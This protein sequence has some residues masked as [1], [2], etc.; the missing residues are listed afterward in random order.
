MFEKCHPKKIKI[1]INLNVFPTPASAVFLLWLLSSLCQP[2]PQAMT[3][4]VPSL[5]LYP[6]TL[7]LVPLPPQNPGRDSIMSGGCASVRPN[8]GPRPQSHSAV[9]SFFKPTALPF[10]L[11]SYFPKKTETL[12]ET[13]LNF[14]LFPLKTELRSHLAFPY[15][16]RRWGISPLCP[17]PWSLSHTLHLLHLSDLL[18]LY[19]QPSPLNWLL[20]S[21]TVLIQTF[22]HSIHKYSSSIYSAPNL[23]QG[24]ENTAMNKSWPLGTSMLESE[25]DG[26]EDQK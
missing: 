13:S 26:G 22:I 23:V 2:G 21:S 1:K 11:T 7:Q 18:V 24:I 8:S 14:L 15:T 12:G 4:Y 5:A 20:P 10:P 6:L 9:L 25:K 3:S 17:G 16:L 19:L